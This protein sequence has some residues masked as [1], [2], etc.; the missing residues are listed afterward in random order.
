MLVSHHM[1]CLHIFACA[2]VLACVPA[3]AY[4]FVSKIIVYEALSY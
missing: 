4:S 3:C 2:H 1:Q